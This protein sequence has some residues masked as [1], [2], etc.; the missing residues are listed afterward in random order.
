[1]ENQELQQKYRTAL[2]AC[3][4]VLS[5]S[6]FLI[7]IVEMMKGSL[8]PIPNMPP[9][10]IKFLPLVFYILAFS[11]VAS[12][13]VLRAL[14]LKKT[15]ETMDT[16]DEPR[17]LKPLSLLTAKPRPQRL[18]ICAI[19]TAAA[20]ETIAILGLVLFLL[21]GLVQ[22]FYVFLAI[23]VAVQVFYFPRASQWDIE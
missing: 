17:P 21:V 6:V 18:L 12:I 10:V 15:D 3:G 20:G 4:A 9:E 8:K 19:L 5:T 7:V 14:L 11:Q 2:I 1:M 23:S 22:E 13:Q 16:T